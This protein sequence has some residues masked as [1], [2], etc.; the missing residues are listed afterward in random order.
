MI[1]RLKKNIYF[2]YLKIT[3]LFN[4]MEEKTQF[5]SEIH[6]GNGG[7]TTDSVGNIVYRT[8]NTSESN[9]DLYSSIYYKVIDKSDTTNN[10]SPTVSGQ[11]ISILFRV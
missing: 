10:S 1:I 9:A 6:F 8:T 2:K 4:I 3:K 11:S 7:T 5:I